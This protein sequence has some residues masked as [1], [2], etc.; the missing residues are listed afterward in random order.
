MMNQ[1]IEWDTSFADSQAKPQFDLVIPRKMFR[2]FLNDITIRFQM[3]ISSNGGIKDF[4]CKP[5]S[6]WASPI[7]GNSKYLQVGL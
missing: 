2:Y 6:Y 3:E 4:H 7:Y 1:W 5:T